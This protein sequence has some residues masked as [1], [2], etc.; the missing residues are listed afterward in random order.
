MAGPASGDR[1][2]RRRGQPAERHHN[3]QPGSIPLAK[4]GRSEAPQIVLRI[5]VHC[6]FEAAG[7]VQVSSNA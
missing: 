3:C 4:P 1:Y 6:E 2:R 7:S 5:A